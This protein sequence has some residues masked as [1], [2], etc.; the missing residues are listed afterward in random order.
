[1]LEIFKAQELREKHFG[2][3]C[4]LS[5]RRPPHGAEWEAEKGQRMAFYKS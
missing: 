2:K 3:N 5:T 1:M 4:L